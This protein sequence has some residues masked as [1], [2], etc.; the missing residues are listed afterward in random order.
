MAEVSSSVNVPPVSWL[1]PKI[2]LAHR[3]TYHMVVEMDITWSNQK[4]KQSRVGSGSS[5]PTGNMGKHIPSVLSS[6]V[7]YL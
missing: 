1:D 2:G 5:F 3:S 7:V 4:R 6:L